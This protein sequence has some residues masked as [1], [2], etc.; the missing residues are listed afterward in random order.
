[1]TLKLDHRITMAVVNVRVRINSVE[2]FDDHFLRHGALR[3]RVPRL[4]DHSQSA[5]PDAFSVAVCA[6]HSLGRQ[7][8]YHRTPTLWL[9]AVSD[10]STAKGWHLEKPGICNGVQRLET[11]S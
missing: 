9:F 11:H 1:M 5:P 10:V 7:I 6:C 8:G 3:R 2:D 4:V